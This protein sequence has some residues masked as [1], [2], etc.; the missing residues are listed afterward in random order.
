VLKEDAAAEK[1]KPASLTIQSR[2]FDKAF[3]SVMP[4]VSMKDQAR[5]D[6]VRDRIAR[7]RSR[8][9]EEE[10]PLADME[11]EEEMPNTSTTPACS[12]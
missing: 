4:S 10:A 8:P 6:R 12:E 11:A 1:G 9:V 5:Y 3:L 2:H 7:A